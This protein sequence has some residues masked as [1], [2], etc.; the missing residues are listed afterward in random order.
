MY[1]AIEVP[2]IK[3]NRE[4]SDFSKSEAKDYFKWFQETKESRLELLVK[5]VNK[6]GDSIIIDYSRNS[7]LELSIWILSKFEQKTNFK[8]HFTESSVESESPQSP[9]DNISTYKDVFSQD[10]ISIIFDFSIYFGETIIRHSSKH[11]WG[12]LLNPKSYIHY[13]QPILLTD[14]P[15][16]NINPRFLIENEMQFSLREKKRIKKEFLLNVFDY[17]IR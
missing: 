13:A 14:H 16:D 15:A 9:K 1:P 4:F 7:I 2:E 6:S 17:A 8:S 3:Q 11:K 10:L 12:Y 5:T